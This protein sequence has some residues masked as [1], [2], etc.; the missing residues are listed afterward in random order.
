MRRRRTHAR[1]PV[2]SSA[3]NLFENHGN[4]SSDSLEFCNALQWGEN[5]SESQPSPSFTQYVG[6]E[7][8]SLSEQ[9]ESPLSV[10][11]YRWMI[12]LFFLSILAALTVLTYRELIARNA[13]GHGSPAPVAVDNRGPSEASIKPKPKK[14]RVQAADSTVIAPKTTKRRGETAPAEER[15]QDNHFQPAPEWINLSTNK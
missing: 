1:A 11:S 9:M 15:R 14:T 10:C 4:E 7:L 2:S 12:R 3:D 13:G 5:P 8:Q 6:D